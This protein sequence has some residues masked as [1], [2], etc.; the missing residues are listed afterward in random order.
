[1]KR[2]KKYGILAGV[3]VC[4]C[5]ALLLLGGGKKPLLYVD[6]RAVSAQEMSLLD[7]N[8]ERAVWMKQLQEWAREEGVAETFS[9][10][11]LIEELEIENCRRTEQ[12]ESGGIVYGIVEYTPLQYYNLTMG[13]YER[14]LKEKFMEQA[15]ETK[16]REYYESHRKDYLQIGSIEAELTI[17]EEGKVWKVQ[18]IQADQ[19]TI[20]GISERDE[21]LAKYL[22]ELGEGETARWEDQYGRTCQLYCVTKEG[23]IEIPYEQVAGAVLEQYAAEQFTN[24]LEK[25]IESSK[26]EDYRE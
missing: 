26:V 9:Y 19:Y 1:M 13:I 5:G 14:S 3:C 17:W 22:L 20:R 12:K 8:V 2:W 23:D 10:D 24:E 16:L 21:M 15:D 6:G 4:A 7:D 18:E 25:R 11:A